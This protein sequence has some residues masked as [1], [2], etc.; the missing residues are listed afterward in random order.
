M[1]NCSGITQVFPIHLISVY[2]NSRVRMLGTVTPQEG[3]I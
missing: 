3:E 2:H 1:P